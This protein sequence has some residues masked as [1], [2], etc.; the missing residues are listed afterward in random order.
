MKLYIFRTVPLSFI[1]CL[2]T[3][4]VHS[5]IVYVL[6]V[7]GQLSS[8]IRMEIP[9]WSCSNVFYK[10]VWHI[11]LLNVQWISSWWWAEELS[12]TC[13]I[14][15]QNKFV[16]LVHLVGFIIKKFVMM[17]G[18]MNVKKCIIYN[19]IMFI[20]QE[21][22]IWCIHTLWLHINYLRNLDFEFREWKYNILYDRYI[23]E[24][25]LLRNI[26]TGPVNSWSRHSSACTTT[27]YG[28]EGP[29]IESRWG[30]KFS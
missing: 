20:I 28:L 30:P 16:K 21:Y 2:F 25:V 4:R 8:R 26:I 3:G 29:E 6:Q 14:S 27:R 19:Y 5:A 18:H 24:N 1:R 23:Y 15:C 22:G 13:R 9:S 10:P 11:P 7:C 12:E 17:H